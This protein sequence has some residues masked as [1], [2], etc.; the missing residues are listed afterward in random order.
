MEHFDLY[1]AD[2]QP[3]GRRIMRGEPIPHGEYHIVVQVMTINR[4]GEILLT[5]RVPEKTSGGKWECSGGC[6]V[7]GENSRDA[8]KRELFEET[9]IRAEPDDLELE[10][11]LTTDSMLR[12]FYT[13]I[14]DV[15][16]SSLELQESEV[17]AAK[18]VSF[19]RLCEMSRS[20]QTTRTLS[21][22]LE[23]RYLQIKQL[24]RSAVH[25]QRRKGG[26]SQNF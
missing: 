23:N 14:K 7:A 11:S 1:S 13:L 16:L 8:A 25:G 15:P 3:L 10:W 22:W 6:A 2:R 9:G 24:T 19:D 18:W 26:Q 12:D 21:R 17:C 5:Q 20:G 4:D